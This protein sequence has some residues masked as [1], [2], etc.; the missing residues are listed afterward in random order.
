M[1]SV[2]KPALVLSALALVIP[3]LGVL[4]PAG[5]AAPAAEAAIRQSGSTALSPAIVQPGA[6][7]AA[8][9]KARLSGMVKF[10][11]ARKGRPVVVQRKVRGG[12]W[13]KVTTVRQNRAG[14]VRFTGPARNARN[15]PFSYRGVAQRWNGLRAAA[16]KPQ[17]AAVWHMKF[18]DEFNRK[19]L[20]PLWKNRMSNAASR[21]CS[22]VGA[23]RMSRVGGGALH[24]SVK[25]DPN[26][27]G[28][29]CEVSIDGKQVALDY[30]LNGQVSTQHLESGVGAFTRGTF[31]ARIKFQQ[32][33][34]QHGSFWLQPVSPQYLEGRPAASGAEVDVVEFFGKGYPG[35]GLA[36][37]L[38]NYGIDGGKTKIGGVW[39]K[40]TKAL[41]AGDSWWKNYHVFSVEWTRKMYIFRVDGREHFR[42]K[43]GVSGIDEYMILSLLSSDWELAEAKRLGVKPGGT[44]DVDWVRVWQK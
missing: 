28:E 2:L 21:Q 16:S 14:V 25:R 23:R 26:R 35:G 7:V 38:Y 44:M 1:K 3:L 13:Q 10:K 9:K 42:T 11:P 15:K 41:P 33:R 17:S 20:G 12:A 30:Y 5:V 31:A 34:G 6:K 32:N 24:L 40:A 37:F 4:G 8:A 22:T 39:P 18:D 43:R 36:S 27:L 19:R 29:T